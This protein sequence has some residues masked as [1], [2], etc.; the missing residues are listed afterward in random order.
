MLNVKCCVL[1]LVYYK[2]SWWQLT[3]EDELG[4]DDY[5]EE[6]SLPP[7][8]CEC[9]EVKL[10]YLITF[11]LLQTLLMTVLNI[12]KRL[13]CKDLIP[14]ANCCLKLKNLIVAGLRPIMLRFTSYMYHTLL[15]LHSVMSSSYRQ[16]AEKWKLHKTDILI[17]WMEAHPRNRTSKRRCIL[18]TQLVW[19]W[20]SWNTGSPMQGGPS[21]TLIASLKSSSFHHI[22]QQQQCGKA[23]ASKWLALIPHERHKKM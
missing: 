20:N 11:C 14:C 17:D 22:Q 16:A 6:D 9:F 12:R 3:K 15:K 23:G 5:P 10:W 8:N 21:H 1:L 19:Q 13:E 7:C 4:I 18:P 2:R